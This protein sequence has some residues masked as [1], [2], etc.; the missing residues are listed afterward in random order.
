MKSISTVLFVFLASASLASAD[1][2]CPQY[3]P[4]PFSAIETKID[5]GGGDVL[6]GK[7]VDCAKI[8]LG[9][10]VVSG[11]QQM[12]GRELP[13][14][15]SITFRMVDVFDNAF[16]NPQDNSLN[17]PYQ[18][19]MDNY[20]K[21][22]V[23]SIPVWAH[24]FGHSI[25]DNTLAPAAPKW[26]ALIKRRMAG[27]DGEGTVDGPGEGQRPSPAQ[28]L[29][30]IIGGYDEY[31]ADVIAVLYTGKGDAVSRSLFLTGLMA[32]PEGKPGACPNRDPKC[33]PRSSSKKSILEMSVG[34]DFTDRANQLGRWKGVDP[35]DIHNLLAPARY[36]IYKYYISNP[37]IMHEKSKIAGAT[38]DALIADVNRRL[39]RLLGQPG[40][41]TV[42]SVLREMSDVQRINSEFIDAI[43]ATFKKA[44]KL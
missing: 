40:G 19:V 20:S 42:Q 38:V 11:I 12:I 44:F 13:V 5:L 18:M 24:E 32:N 4:R 31:F 15:S 10:K 8:G 36:H 41:V 1:A 28:V 2:V 29:E 6:E 37:L 43:D 16:F 23:Y 26:R 25:L 22:P 27:G 14:P 21:N 39:T 33:R 35:T 9:A 34:R 17:V 7:R 3:M 30:A